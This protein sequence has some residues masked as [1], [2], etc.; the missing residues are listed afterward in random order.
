MFGKTAGEA[1][2]DLLIEW[3]VNHIYGTPGEQIHPIMEYLRMK[4][5]KIKYIQV[6]HEEAGALAASAYAKLTGKLGV[7]I[8]G[9]GPGAIHLMNGLYDAKLDGAPVLA[10]AGQV[11]TDLRGTKY[12]Q[13]VN[14]ERMFDDVAVYNQQI[15]SPEQVPAVVNQ[16]IRM[17]YFHQG[18]SVLTISG[19][20]QAQKLE[21]TKEIR[22]TAPIMANSRILPVDEDVH[23]AVSLLNESKKTVILAGKGAR[24]AR[25]QLLAVADKLA[26]PIVVS[27]AGKGVIPDEHEL[28]IGGLGL[29]GIKPAYTA[30]QEAET[31]VMIGVSFPYNEFLP[32]QAKTVQIDVNA[33]EIGKR[34]PVDI[35]LAGDT[36][37]TLEILLPLLQQNTDN[38][39]LQKHQEMMRNWWAN[40]EKHL[41]SNDVPIKPQVVPFI[42]EKV[43]EK[44][45][46]LSVDVGNVTTWM[47]RYFKVTEQKFIVSSWLGTMGCGLPGAIAAKLAF[48]E[49]QVVAVC[50][51][52]GF[53]MTMSDFVTAVKYGLPMVVIILNNQSLGMIKFEQEV[54]GNAEFETELIN[55]DFAGYANICGGI[56]FRVEKQDELMPALKKAFA[57]NR[58]CIIDVIVANE[59]PWPSHL[60]V[61]QATGYTKHLIKEAFSK[62]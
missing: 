53:S 14:L 61:Y 9:S 26:A 31:L 22:F 11:L 19:D 13:E 2:V 49:K 45:A 34:Y 23:Q 29:L 51:D 47:A 15:V 48:P 39:Y 59:P 46:I 32:E 52:G 3:G 56:G 30:V 44:D 54:R 27:L 12:F 10:I 28:C 20:I 57:A 62:L 6:R 43:V 4:K 1:L 41:K 18:V 35:G 55:P 24:G 40:E 21:M 25:E 37:N 7:C 58:P 17:A 5:D 33:S 60:T 42:L 16:A 8:A 50:G 36:K 38:S